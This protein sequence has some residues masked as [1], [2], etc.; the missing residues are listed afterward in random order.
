M[1]STALVSRLPAA[2]TRLSAE[3]PAYRRTALGVFVG[4]FGTFAMVYGLQPLM[5]KLSHTFDVSPA[6]ASGVV[7]ATTGMLAVG[8]IP[9]SLLADKLGRK[10]VMS[11][12]LALGAIL[13]LVCA[14]APDFGSLLLLRGLLGLA[15]A[16]LPAAAM[17]YLSEEMEPSGL[18]RVMG[19]YIAGNGLGGMLGRFVAALLA[20]WFSWQLVT[21]AIGS[22][23]AICAWL[24][25][26]N[27][28]PSRHFQPS[29]VALT[30]VWR[31]TRLH[32][33]DKG[34][35]WLFATPFLLMGGFV[36]LYNYLSYRLHDAPFNLSPGQLGL[37]FALYIVG[38]GASAWAG[39]LADQLGRRNV[40]WV[41][42]GSMVVGLLLTLANWLP[43]I[44]AGLA[45]CTLG[46]F[47]AHAV[48]SSWVG[49]RALRARALAS[50]IY[51][52]AFYLGGSVLGWASG[53]LWEVAAWPGVVGFLLLVLL[54]CLAITLRLRK[55]APLPVSP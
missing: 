42:V 6:T 15:L 53:L 51:L 36:S 16:G 32:F 34:L 10:P 1:S 43:L 44:I 46:F 47:G 11:L 4:G 41:M 54:A 40:L 33:S 39:R 27:L 24:F 14:L 23:G 19:L 3:S 25:W 37:V 21:L 22:M 5:P 55:L 12:S 13:M 2:E 50:A 17:A 29:S 31:D 49:R 35:P 52:T 45:I 28:P 26:R 30:Q 9:A 8:L 38:M 18:G 7:S 48:A 20:E